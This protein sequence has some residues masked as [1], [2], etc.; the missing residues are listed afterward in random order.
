MDTIDSRQSRFQLLAE[1]TTSLREIRGS[2]LLTRRKSMF[3][4][5]TKTVIFLTLKQLSPAPSEKES[6]LIRK[7]DFHSL[8][9][10][11]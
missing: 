5:S 10:R 6:Y 4:N 9:I 8:Y 1:L 3:E 7:D 2:L 11:Q